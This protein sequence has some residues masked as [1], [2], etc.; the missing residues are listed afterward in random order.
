ME[1][2]LLS[3]LRLSPWDQLPGLSSFLHGTLQT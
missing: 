2:V 3:F 1:S